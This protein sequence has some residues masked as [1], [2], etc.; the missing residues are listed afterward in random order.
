MAEPFAEL[1]RP[2]WRWSRRVLRRERWRRRL[3]SAAAS[4]VLADGDL[5][6]AAA[7]PWWVWTDADMLRQ[8]NGPPPPPAGGS[9]PA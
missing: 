3:R 9:P 7:L 4:L 2:L 1:T 5:L 6:W 8:L